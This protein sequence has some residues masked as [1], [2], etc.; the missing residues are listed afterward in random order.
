M[1][2]RGKQRFGGSDTSKRILELVEKAEAAGWRVE[3]AANG[4]RVFPP[5]KTKS[6]LNIHFTISDVK[7]YMNTKCRFRR[8]GLDV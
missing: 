6:P 3:M 2:G 7:A 4:W 1:S 8:A 5:D